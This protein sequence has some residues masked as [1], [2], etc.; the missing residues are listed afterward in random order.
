MKEI[1]SNYEKYLKNNRIPIVSG[2]WNS[3]EQNNYITK[4]DKFF[5]DKSSESEE[6]LENE[7]NLP[8]NVKIIMLIIQVIM[9]KI[10]N[11]E[12]IKIFQR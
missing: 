7:D 12:K 1:K 8:P 10:K 11:L 5:G 3:D 2:D 6:S 4:K 9:I